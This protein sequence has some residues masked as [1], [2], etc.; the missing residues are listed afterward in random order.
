MNA[1]SPSHRRARLMLD[2]LAE[3]GVVIRAARAADG[4]WGIRFPDQA[5]HSSAQR[6]LAVD[7]ALLGIAWPR[8]FGVL[9]SAL[10]DQGASQ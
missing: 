6:E 9:I 1:P 5:Q 2:R 10:R 8:A 3:A 4:K 7:A